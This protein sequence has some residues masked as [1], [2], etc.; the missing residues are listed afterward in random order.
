MLPAPECETP[1]SG[2]LFVAHAPATGRALT[3]RFTWAP[4]HREWVCQIIL[5]CVRPCLPVAAPS[6]LSSFLRGFLHQHRQGDSYSADAF[7]H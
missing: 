7:V 1:E 5:H 3:P 6:T 4:G 2:S